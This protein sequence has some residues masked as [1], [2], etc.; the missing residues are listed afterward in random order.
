MKVKSLIT[1]MILIAG[2]LLGFFPYASGGSAN[3]SGT[4]IDTA[5]VNKLASVEGPVEAIVTF[6]GQEALS[7][8]HLQVLREAG[9]T[10][11]I[12]FE[13]LPMAGVLITKE[14][15]DQL[16]EKSEIRSIYFNHDVEYENEGSTDL[17]GVDRVRTSE[18]FR[19][20]NDGLPVSGSGVGVVV[21]DSGVDGTHKDHEYPSHLVQN[22]D[23]SLNLHA[24]SEF[25][26]ITYLENVP[27]TDTDS[28]H[29]THVAGIVGG[30]GAMSGGKY[31]GVA[32]GADLIGYGSGA[33]V[34]ILDTIGGF[35][36]ALTHQHEYDIRV[37]TNSWG[38]TSDVGTAFDPHDPINIATKKLY[39]RGIVTVFSAGN[40]GPGQATI[41]GNYKKAPWVITVAAGTKDGKLADFSSR[42]VDG[43]GG[44]V[45]VD[46]EA[47]TWEDRPTITAPGVGIIST[48]VVSPL[49]SLGA[50][51]D[52]E[53][54]DPGHLPYYTTMSGTSM[55]APH[56]AGVVALLLEA[57]PTLSP[58]EVKQLIQDTATNMPGYELWETG[59]GYVNAYAAVDAAFSDKSYGS[60]VNMNRTFHAEVETEVDYDSF[61][62]EYDPLNL[63]GNDYA[64]EVEE[65]IDEVTA[66][67]NAKGLLEETGNT[68]NLLLEAPDGTT[69]S[70]GISVLFPLYTD[71]TVQV[72]DPVP[73]TWKV[74]LEG[75][76]GTLALPETI[77]GE[78]ALKSATGYSGLKD[79]SGHPT[80]AAIKM[81]VSER[82]IDS[83]NDQTYKPDRPL[84]RIEL[85][86][87]LVMGAG[88][89][90]SL[91]SEG[92]SSFRD[93]KDENRAFA[94]AVTAKGAALLDKQQIHNGVMLPTADE[95]F[96]EKQAVT[97]A[98]LAFSLVQSLGLQ[99][100]AEQ[101][102]GEQLTVRH[103]GERVAVTDEA[104]VPAELKGYVQLALDLNILNAYFSVSQGNYDLQPT[105]EAS[106]KPDETVTRGDY[107][108]AITRYYQTYFK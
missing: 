74:K 96:S 47:W 19:K 48:R 14:Q 72:A 22:V 89:V 99:E 70:S 93:V 23:A 5:L 3:T 40:S 91:P 11:G 69:Y 27:N 95:E 77:E 13:S 21:N 49:S 51:D 86:K 61:A 108:V 71:R 41:S 29:G 82:L 4:V 85:A 17:T 104:D 38:S 88:V 34:T 16:K 103:K 52:A 8:S 6:E 97:R 37:I 12:T 2:L 26:P 106:F 1:T 55:A 80:E 25:L 73:G 83:F 30:T 15:M 42:G 59:A 50:A 44:K 100:E 53:N 33:A 90:Q 92:T 45:V 28:G 65:G 60:T 76:E 31:E 78:L 68:V 107:A 94:E 58:L 57:D 62:I 105:I 63:S 35:D 9:I 81:A 46:G 36:Y 24:V 84:E 56:I 43:K 32:P 18:E 79:I 66:R 102:N 67:I 39:D 101:L 64:F 7:S 98:E 20:K 75:L 87:F 54:I 10:K